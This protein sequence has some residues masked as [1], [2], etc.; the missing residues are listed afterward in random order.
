[1][2]ESPAKQPFTHLDPVLGA[3]EIRPLH[4]PDDIPLVRS[5]LREDRAR[6][7]GMQA[8]DEAAL[9]EFYRDL[10]DSGKGD[11]FIG[12]H[13]GHPAFLMECYDPARDPVG[14]H[15][16]VQPGDL[17]M[18]IL[19]APGSTPLKGF[20]RAVF[21]SIMTFMFNHLGA[22]RIV[23]EPDTRNDAIHR[24]NRSAGFV[25]ER[26]IELS[27]KT[28]EL[29]FCTRA[30]FEAANPNSHRAPEPRRRTDPREVSDHLS[31]DLWR[32]VNRL[33]VR[34]AIS[35]LSHE[36]VLAPDPIEGETDRY[37]LFADD[38]KL[39]YRFSARCITL[40][41]WL[42]DADSIEKWDG[43]QSQ[44]IDASRFILEFQQQL[45]IGEAMLPTYLEEIASTLYGSAFK[46]HR[47]GPSA[48]EL[49][50]ADFQTVEAGMTEGHPCFIANN[51]RIGFDTLDYPAYAPEAGQPVQLLWLAAHRD[52]TV[53][54]ST[55][56]LDY[57]SLLEDE[58]GEGQLRRF[59]DQLR[60]DGHDPAAFHLIPVHPW[61][62]YNKLAYLFAK[63]LAEGTLVCLGYGEDQ[64]RA[65]QSIRTFFNQDQPEKR[66]VKTALSI[67]N[68]GFMRGLSPYYMSTTPAINDFIHN[69]ISQDPYLSGTGFSI[70]REVAGVGYMH[71][72]FETTLDKHS[73]YR[74][75]LS[76]LWRE[77]PIP[78]LKPGQRLMTMASL[79]HLDADGQAVLPAL[80][81]ASGLAPEDWLRRYL[82]AYLSPLL[83]CFY[84]HD[85]V[86]M[87]HGENLILVLDDQVPVRMIMKDIA[88]EVAIMNEEV[89]LADKVQRLAVSVPEHLK[90]LSIFTDVFDCIFRFIGG[91]L[92]EQGDIGEARFWEL[93]AE[94][95]HDYQA[96]HP[97]M[98]EKFAQHDLFAPE[99]T[100]SCLNRLQL[101]NNQQM[102][103]LTDPAAN[104][105]FAGTLKNPIAAYAKRPEKATASQD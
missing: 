73:P 53:F 16:A 22:R 36:R 21:R 68:M 77:S 66:Y 87:P 95:V 98:A 94:C 44:P 45:G 49:T 42:V 17:G 69:L 85:L 81:R 4:V 7:W 33:L 38:G 5:W 3:F 72:D 48:E 10:P 90:I 23:V 67:L 40:D 13:H 88:E 86:F 18:H 11:A 30:Q 74:K 41:H 31:K 105:Q 51:G 8:M 54:A 93:V 6:Y 12:Y 26:T 92:E 101:A 100:L 24:L 103:N 75:M 29:A 99:F 47:R 97:H 91:I 56:T 35:E 32:H 102:I 46:L 37:R 25:Y 43:D 34:K 55:D 20:T 2:N 15:Y 28:A 39:E 63:S 83:H 58:L 89:V 27:E 65:Q 76:A 96:A 82:K 14:E 104:L 64:Y 79:L 60:K 78:T 84:A 19:V 1:M 57:R 62:W 52:D 71:P 61:Q 50:R 9:A 59:E 70:L 80:M